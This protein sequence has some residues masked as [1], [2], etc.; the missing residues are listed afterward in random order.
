VS[1]TPTTAN[2]IQADRSRRFTDKVAFVTGA[3]GGIGRV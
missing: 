2:V 1:T 3:G